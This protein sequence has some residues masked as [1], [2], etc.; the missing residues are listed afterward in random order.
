MCS[1]RGLV[2]EAGPVQGAV[3]PLARSVTGE[4]AARCGSRRA[5]A[6]ARPTMT[7]DRVRDRRTRARRGPSTARRGTR[8]GARS[9]TCSRQATRRG[10]RRQ[11]ATSRPMRT[12]LS[13]TTGESTAGRVGWPTSHASITQTKSDPGPPPS[14][15][16]VTVRRRRPA[17]RSRDGPPGCT[18]PIPVGRRPTPPPSA[19]ARRAQRRRGVRLAAR[20]HPRDRRTRSPSSSG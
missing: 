16:S 4:H 7:T 20:T 9:A 17:R 5:R 18:W 11:S 14:C 15:S 2:G 13:R 3:Q 6:G 12:M 1:L 10:Q 8:P 19:S